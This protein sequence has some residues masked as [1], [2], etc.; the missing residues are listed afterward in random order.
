MGSG[1]LRNAL[2]ATTTKHISNLHIHLNDYNASVVAR[3]VMILNI[4]SAPG[5]NPE[6]D[7]DFAFLWDL[8]YNSE[9]PDTTRN[10]FNGV[11]KD[12][13]DGRL[14]ENIIIAKSSHLHILRTV[15]SSWQV[16]TSKPQPESDLLMKR[17]KKER[18]FKLSVY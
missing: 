13:L 4:L 18:Y 15:W 12:L 8:W 5:F 6:N 17:I 9:W 2:Q 10:R 14:R 7:K 11:V 1:D 16:T 3:N